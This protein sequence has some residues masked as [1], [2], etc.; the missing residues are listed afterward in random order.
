MYQKQ[1]SETYP[2]LSVLDLKGAGF[3]KDYEQFTPQVDSTVKSLLMD[4][5][6]SLIAGLKSLPEEE[7]A[8]LAPILEQEPQQCRPIYQ[9][10]VKTSL[11]MAGFINGY[12]I[13]FADLCDTRRQAVG[14]GGHPADMI[15]AALALCDLPG[16]T[17]KKVLEAIDLGYHMWAVLYNEMMYKSPHLDGT[18]ALALTVPVMAALVKEK[19]PEQMQNALNLSAMGGAVVV[20]VRSSKIVTNSKSGA[21][22][23]AI[24]RAFWCDKMSEFLQATPTMFTGAKGWSKMVAPLDGAFKAYEDDAVYGQIQFKAFP[25]CN[26]NQVAT[27]AA[28]YLHTAVAD[29]LDQIARIHIQVCKKDSTLA[30]RPGSPK[31]PVDHPS[32]DHHIQ[33]CTAVGLKY[34]TLAP[35]HYD[36]E[37]L[38]DEEIRGLI[39]KMDVTILTDEEFAAL[40]GEDGAG[41]LSVYLEDGTK[42]EERLAR[43]CGLYTGLSGAERTQR[44]RSTVEAKRAMIERSYN[45]DLSVVAGIVSGF[46]HYS[47]KELLDAI[48]NALIG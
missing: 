19:T 25:C 39:D 35:K 46:E 10:P 5:I 16:V 18:S 37:V 27:E 22:G 6:L 40:G 29:R 2:D 47:G 42:L 8:N 7:L 45:M 34:G 33:F 44:M 38:Q 15:A 3:W 31:Y 43:P 1:A 9:T 14:R 11:E 30:I 12:C 24:A 32:A 13:R 20:E 48:Q 26:A 36:E 17:G 23:Y 28:T 21:T 41:I 4:A